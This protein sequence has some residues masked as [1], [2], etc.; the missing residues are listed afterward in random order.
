VTAS[1]E[2]GN[3]KS[4]TGILV[5]LFFVFLRIGAFTWGGG[6]AM[7]PL[8]KSAVVDKRR[9]LTTE[10]FLDGVAVAQSLPGALAVNAATFVGNRVM[11]TAGALT[12]ACGAILP[13]FI[14]LI[15]VSAFFLSFR[16]FAPVQ[17]FFK[18]AVPAVAA[19]LLNTV[20]EMGKEAL[21][22]RSEVVIA[23]ALLILLVVFNL[24]PVPVILLAGLLGLLRRERP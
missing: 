24:H 20:F 23:V 10:A 7:L 12:A 11:G 16:E 13:S 6:Y 4:R 21:K 2:K 22:R 18:G 5:S 1:A 19:L 3:L 9:W 17:N 14:A 15:L 8:I